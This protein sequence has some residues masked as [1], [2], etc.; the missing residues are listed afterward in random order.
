MSSVVLATGWQSQI[1]YANESTYAVPPT[2][3][4]YSWP[5]VVDT[6]TA[7]LDQQTIVLY[8]LDGTTRF[9]AYLLQGAQQMTVEVGYYPQDVTLLTALVNNAISTSLTWA[10]NYTNVGVP[11]TIVGSRSN[12][13][14]IQGTT[15][16][17]IKVTA[18]M[19]AQ[20]MSQSLPT[21]VTF[22][23]DPGTTPFYFANTT[24]QLNG[25]TIPRVLNFRFTISNNPERVYQF[26]QPYVRVLP[27]KNATVEGTLNV[28][29]QDA[30]DINN[31]ITFGF[32]TLAFQLP[33]AHSVTISNVKF[34][35]LPL[36][37]RPTDL[38]AYDL[39][40]KG[41]GVTVA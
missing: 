11:V 2:S 41:E 8:R 28:T 13:V 12:T 31:V 17:A 32:N 25:V 27:M 15:G 14:A 22:P 10:L 38:I 26:G 40:F 35:N 33:N 23:S 18:N 6:V 1:A 21:G 5:G 37:A 16:Q 34:D 4:T 30:S 20:T 29:I 9:P 36:P 7:T 39:R 19:F 24:V 3:S